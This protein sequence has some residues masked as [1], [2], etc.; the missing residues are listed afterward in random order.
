MLI[1]KELNAFKNKALSTRQLHEAKKQII[2]QIGLAQ[3][4]GGALMFNLGKSLMLFD[5]IDTLEEIFQ[6]VEEITASQMLEVSN[7]IFD[8]SKMSSLTYTY[9]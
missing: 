5:R 9:E 7:Y 1:W 4:S 6:K 8:E 2:G 3:D